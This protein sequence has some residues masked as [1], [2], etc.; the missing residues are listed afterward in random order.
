MLPVFF[1]W[2]KKKKE[3]CPRK[4]YHLPSLLEKHTHVRDK[5][6]DFGFNFANCHWK[7]KG[8]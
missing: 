5:D 8:K 4:M 1:N 7:L 2:K 6:Q 3:G